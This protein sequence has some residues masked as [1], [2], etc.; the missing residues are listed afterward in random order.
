VFV[1]RL[2][3]FYTNG[4]DVDTVI[5]DGKILMQGRRVAS[6]DE[7]AVLEMAQEEAARAFERLDISAYLEMDGD[8]WRGW[9]Y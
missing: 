2:L 9:E 3:A 4:N 6:V 7:A 1:P 5:V 8:F